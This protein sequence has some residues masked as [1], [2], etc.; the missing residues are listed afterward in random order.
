M[1]NIRPESIYPSQVFQLT[2]QLPVSLTVTLQPQL[3]YPSLVSHIG[4]GFSKKCSKSVA[5]RLEWLRVVT[6]TIVYLFD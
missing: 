3:K 1:K 4:W 6:G 5:N 2:L